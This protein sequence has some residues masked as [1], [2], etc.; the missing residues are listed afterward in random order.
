M[1]CL[2][3]IVNVGIVALHIYG[4]TSAGIKLERIAK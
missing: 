2:G 4:E 1:F 3:K